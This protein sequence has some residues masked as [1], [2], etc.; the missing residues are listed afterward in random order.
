MTDGSADPL[1]HLGRSPRIV[2]LVVGALFLGQALLLGSSGG[3]IRRYDVW[4][5]I[6]DAMNAVIWIAAISRHALTASPL[7]RHWI[8][9]TC[10]ALGFAAGDILGLVTE[11]VLTI[12]TNPYV[13]TTKDFIYV[14]SFAPW[15]I[16]ISLP[17]FYRYF[18]GF[19][20]IDIIQ[21]IVAAVAVYTLLFGGTAFVAG[22]HPAAGYE[23]VTL[24]FDFAQI[25]IVLFLLIRFVCSADRLY[26]RFYFF[27][28]V[29]MGS[30]CASYAFDTAFS[31]RL[32]SYHAVTG[33]T[34]CAA[35][36]ANLL[37]LLYCF[38]VGRIMVATNPNRGSVVSEIVDAASPVISSFGLI[39]L[40]LLV[41]LPP[42]KWLCVI[43]AFVS[44]FIRS[45]TSLRSLD[46]AQKRL[47]D[48]TLE[49]KALSFTDALTGISNRRHIDEALR[50]AWHEG[51]RSNVALSFILIDVD[52]FKGINDSLGHQ[53]G[54]ACLA[55]ISKE[56][57]STMPRITDIVGRYGG[58]EFAA[59]LPATDAGSSEL[60]AAKLCKAVRALRMPHPTAPGG[61]ATVSLGVATCFDFA[62]V[63]V[64]DLI[65]AADEALYRAKAAGR[66][67]WRSSR[68]LVPAIDGAGLS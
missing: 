11:H 56:I 35:A 20:W 42:I 62:T 9:M 30:T 60:M 5:Q 16:L 58:D 61:I 63:S 49:L 48:A 32:M 45:T 64:E 31:V 3:N 65:R 41:E 50:R 52:L 27:A 44:F 10:S 34:Q 12:S 40:G 67:G 37:F 66:D 51:N 68:C 26:R 24:A 14:M 57:R 25:Y 23:V 43:T 13:A 4:W 22:P 47:E 1:W 38:P 28:F 53:A 7:R 17:S 36:Q 8:L 54:D 55:G 15:F 6:T 39:L 21:A 29:S 2:V 18:R 33:I 59:I 19:F 46:L